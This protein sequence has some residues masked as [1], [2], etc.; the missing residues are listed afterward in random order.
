MQPINKLMT[1]LHLLFN[2]LANRTYH[3]QVRT[4]LHLR[5]IG[6]VRNWLG[7]HILTLA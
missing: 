4:P 7:Q 6:I 2:S 1:P 5:R 3:I